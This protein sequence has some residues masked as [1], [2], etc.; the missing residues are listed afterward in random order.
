MI[1]YIVDY[2]GRDEFWKIC[3]IPHANGTTSTI[4]Y[5]DAWDI[6]KQQHTKIAS[7]VPKTVNTILEYNEKWI[8]EQGLTLKS[9]PNVGDLT[10]TLFYKSMPGYLKVTYTF[11]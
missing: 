9:K 2:K 7:D 3:M 4:S 1:K 5:S 6:F 8:I 10:E 11:K